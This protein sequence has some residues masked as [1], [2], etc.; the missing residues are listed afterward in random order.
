M[1]TFVGLDVSTA[2]SRTA[3]GRSACRSA[4]QSAKSSCSVA[5]RPMAASAIRS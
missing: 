4:N 5:S 1:E 2:S 3:M